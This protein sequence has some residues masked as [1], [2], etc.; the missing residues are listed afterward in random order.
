MANSEGETLPTRPVK[1]PGPIEATPAQI[2]ER[3]RRA[4]PGHTKNPPLSWPGQAA[5]SVTH[6]E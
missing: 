1:L 6:I 5:L 4:P 3:R 2:K